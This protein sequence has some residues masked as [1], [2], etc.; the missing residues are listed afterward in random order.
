MKID[1][2]IIFE[3]KELLVINKPAGLVVHGDGRTKEK[4]LADFILE[5]Y[6]EMKDVGEPLEVE[7]HKASKVHKVDFEEDQKDFQLPTFNFITIPRPGIV[8][9]L[10]RDTSGVL[11]VAKTQGMFDFLKKQ[12]QS[13]GIKKTYHAF[14]YGWPAKDE[15]EIVASIARSRKDFRLWSAQ[16]GKKGK[17]RD[18]ITLYKVIK[19]FGDNKTKEPTIGHRFSFLELSPQTGRTH[20]I[21]VHLKYLNYPVVSDSLY[22]PRRSKAL[23]FKRHALH[24][25]QLECKLPDGSTHKFEAPYTEDFSEAVIKFIDKK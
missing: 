23:G 18:A 21:R 5:K 11:L 25:F 24:A 19:R 12:F 7:N 4:T 20:Q 16:R 17:E 9:R 8:H 6:P 22:A 2:M 1:G 10:D 14:V 13:H 3:N 15:G